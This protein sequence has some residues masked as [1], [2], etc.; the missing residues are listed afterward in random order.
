M[1]Y[2]TNITDMVA[3]KSLN[4]I[5]GMSWKSTIRLATGSAS[6]KANLLSQGRICCCVLY[7]IAAF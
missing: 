7:F 4:K 2:T 6:V 1:N 5:G 3:R